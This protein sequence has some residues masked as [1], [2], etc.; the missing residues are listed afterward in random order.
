[1][2]AKILL[3]VGLIFIFGSTIL[4]GIKIMGSCSPKIRRVA[5]IGIVIG[6]LLA[7]IGIAV[8]GYQLGRS[9]LDFLG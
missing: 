4:G 8:A 5:L 6:F 9:I 3:V 1:M 2:L 7:N